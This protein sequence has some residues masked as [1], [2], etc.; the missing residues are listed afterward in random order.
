MARLFCPKIPVV[1][2]VIGCT[3]NHGQQARESKCML[4]TLPGVTS[5]PRELM[6]FLWQGM[7]VRWHRKPVL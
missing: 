1:R 3:K 2:A 5:D 7:E 6:L 4:Q